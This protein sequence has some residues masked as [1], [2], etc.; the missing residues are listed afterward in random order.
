MPWWNFNWV[1]I[2][3]ALD[4]WLLTIFFFLLCIVN[5]NPGV[6]AVPHLEIVEQPTDR[7]FRFRY[8]SEMHGTHGS[9][10]GLQT[11]RSRR[12]Y[13]AVALKNFQ[14]FGTKALIRCTLY[15]VP[16]EGSVNK[17]S[18]H[19]HKL[20]IR[21]GDVEESDPHDVEVS[22]LNNFTAMWVFL[23]KYLPSLVE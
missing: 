6:L 8:K 5:V 13:P 17:R 10:M 3:N 2:G 20:V 23:T 11:E 12:T 16:S 21:R 1:S 14:S 9:L 22:N 19:S 15:Q 7:P 4:I 18:P